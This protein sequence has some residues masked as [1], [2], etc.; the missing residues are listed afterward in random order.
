MD[1]T[2]PLADRLIGT[3]TLTSFALV[4][5][6]GPTIAPMGPDVAGYA[7]WGGDGW[8]S[9]LIEAAGRPLY[10]RPAPDGGTDAQT[11]AAAR[12]FLA[13]AGPYTVDEPTG[14]VSQ[15]LRHCLVPNWVGDVHVREVRFLADDRIELS[16][17]AVQTPGGE[18]RFV[19]AFDRRAATA[20]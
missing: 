6:G 17:D 1:R 4:V 14:S 10:D 12:T 13:Y 15:R 9:F 11:I 2:S 5:D 18:G 16:S 3:W 8:M 20:I 19:L 7:T